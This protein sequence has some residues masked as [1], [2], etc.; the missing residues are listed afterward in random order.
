L[1][2]LFLKAF[3]VLLLLLSSNVE[4]FCRC[5]PN[6][7]RE[8]RQSVSALLSKISINSNPTVREKIRRKEE[9]K[10]EKKQKSSEE[11]EL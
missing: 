10:G 7:K 5:F 8:K 1:F 2:N 4:A 11:G 6:D 3:I 9:K